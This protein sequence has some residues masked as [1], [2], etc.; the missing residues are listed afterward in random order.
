MRRSLLGAVLLFTLS[1][2]LFAVVGI[3]C[4]F[5]SEESQ[6][7][8]SGTIETVVF[9]SVD[10]QEIAMDLYQPNK[11]AQGLSPVHVYVHGGGW[12]SK[13]RHAARLPH[14]L[15]VFELMGDQG[16]VGISADHRLVGGATTLDDAVADVKDLLRYLRL[17]GRDHGIDPDRMSLW[18]A[19]SGGHLALMA[20]LSEQGEFPGDPSLSGVPARVA[21]VVSWYGPTDLSAW[22]RSSVERAMKLE[23]VLRTT[24]DEDPG[25]YAR[26]SPISYLD[27]KTVPVLLVSGESDAETPPE[28]SIEF[29]KAALEHGF[30]C[31]LVLVKGAG[32]MFML[33]PSS[34]EVLH[35]IQRMT[36]DFLMGAGLVNSG[37][38][39]SGESGENRHGTFTVFASGNE[40]QAPATQ[41][42]G[43]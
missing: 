6:E 18:G 8:F 29:Y 16:W 41:D 9:K 31:S 28:Q 40:A 27:G 14:T 43:Q 19:S 5:L 35:D 4:G 10:G 38:I 13:D 15:G 37:S 17:F 1:I 26:L 33:P 39:R 12:V 22:S 3:T 42:Q 20:A 30:P 36:A 25:E 21:S 34:A 32:H 7:R 24:P 23:K 2:F 11:P